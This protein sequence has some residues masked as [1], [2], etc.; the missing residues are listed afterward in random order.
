MKKFL[1]GTTLGLIALAGVAPSAQAAEN[2][3]NAYGVSVQHCLKMS[4]GDAIQA[5]RDAHP[6]AKMTAKTI[7]M[8]PHCAA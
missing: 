6:G 1:I 5:G 2:P 4:V 7:A 3:G 8:S